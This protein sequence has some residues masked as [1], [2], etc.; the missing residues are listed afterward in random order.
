MS[1]Q[2]GLAIAWL[3]CNDCHRAFENHNRLETCPDGRLQVT[4]SD[5]SFSFTSCG[6]FFC[7]NCIEQATNGQF[8]CKVCGEA[9]TR[10]KVEGRVAKNLE[11]YIKP[12]MTLL[13]D[14]MGV[15]L[16]WA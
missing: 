11:Q 10:Y 16:V 12:P 4:K 5:L 14:A 1:K 6:H 15:M 8:M 13:E 3:H 2:E 7:Q 9:G